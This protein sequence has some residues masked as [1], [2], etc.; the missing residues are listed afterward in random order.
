MK[1]KKA[2]FDHTKIPAPNKTCSPDER[3]QKAPEKTKRLVPMIGGDPAPQL[4]PEIRHL[5][6]IYQDRRVH[7]IRDR[8]DMIC[9]D[10]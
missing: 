7:Q 1:K 2:A 8:K 4:D 3:K 9:P 5:T 10:E 6:A